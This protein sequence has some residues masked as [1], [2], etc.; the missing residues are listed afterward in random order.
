MPGRA[1]ERRDFDSAGAALV[2]LS[3]GNRRFYPCPAGDG[4]TRLVVL[5][6]QGGRPLALTALVNRLFRERAHRVVQVRRFA[7]LRR[8][9]EASCGR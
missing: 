4:S 3:H 8:R 6:A 5:G 7:G 1:P 9:A 2:P